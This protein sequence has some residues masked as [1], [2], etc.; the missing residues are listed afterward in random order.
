MS[1][2]RDFLRFF[3]AHWLLLLAIALYL[4]AVVVSPERAAAAATVSVRSLLSVALLVL[5]V[6]GLVGILQVWISRDLVAR[7]LGKEAGLK[8]LLLAAVC[9]MVLIGPAY[10]V[11]P[12]LMS[13]RLQGAR[14]AVI[15]IVLASY[16]VKLHMIPL[17]VG[18]LGWQFSL[19]RIVLTLVFAI[20]S[21]LAM[22]A[23]L[24]TFET[25]RSS[26]PGDAHD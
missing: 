22:E 10:I 25:N 26:L 15:V 9:G 18:F 17:E 14:W 23:F 3:G 19:L 1:R 12:L 16:T 8:A 13:L 20:P 2:L 24:D 5:A 4:W 11:F 21:G 6:M 7:M